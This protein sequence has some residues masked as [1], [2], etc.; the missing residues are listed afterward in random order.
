LLGLGASVAD[1]SKKSWLLIWATILIAFAGAAASACL[2]RWKPRWGMRPLL[3][4]GTA[5]VIVTILE[6]LELPSMNSVWPVVLAGV[7]LLYLW[8]LAGLFFDLV[9]VWHRYIRL[10][11]T[12]AYLK[13]IRHSSPHGG[14]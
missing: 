11:F 3:V 9:F 12:T 14:N 4:W 7:A 5:T 6:M 10:D 8:W 1:P 13:S 2:S